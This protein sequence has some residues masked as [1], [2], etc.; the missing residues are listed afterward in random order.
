MDSYQD[1]SLH[2][3]ELVNRLSMERQEHIWPDRFP[4]VFVGFSKG[5]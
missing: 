3:A 5:D 1:S 4:D 2:L